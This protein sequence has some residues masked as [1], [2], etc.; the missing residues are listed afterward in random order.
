MSVF[1]WNVLII[2]LCSILCDVTF[3]FSK[4]AVVMK[5]QRFY[6]AFLK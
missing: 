3:G 5:F 1:V 2:F 6:F 4:Y